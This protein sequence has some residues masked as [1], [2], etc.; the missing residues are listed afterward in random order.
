MIVSWSWQ[1]DGVILRSKASYDWGND[2]FIQ[3]VRQLQIA[4]L[5]QLEEHLR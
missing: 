5:E 1:S 4:D 3:E 2:V